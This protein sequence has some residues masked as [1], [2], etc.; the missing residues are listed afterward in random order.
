MV[1]EKNWKINF[2]YKYILKFLKWVSN[3]TYDKEFYLNALN[4][5]GLWRFIDLIW[6]FF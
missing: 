6:N 5:E 1:Q 4:S 2:T 3:T